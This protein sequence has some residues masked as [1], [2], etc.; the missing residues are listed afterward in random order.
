MHH[1]KRLNYAYMN[2][3]ILIAL[4]LSVVSFL[5]ASVG[6]GGASGYIAVLSLFNVPAATY[7]PLVLVLN[8][9]IAGMAFIQFYRAGYFRWSLCWPFLITSIPFAFA[10]SRVAVHD[11][12]YNLLLGT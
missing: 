10:G 12:T 5:Y 4:F 3:Y 7:K 6:H 1:K 11:K 2:M 8:I 9:I